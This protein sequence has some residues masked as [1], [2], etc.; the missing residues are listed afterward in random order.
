MPIVNS[1][2]ELPEPEA[3]IWRYMSLEKLLALLQTSR[4]VFSALRT[5]RDP[6]EGRFPTSAARLLDNRIGEALAK[7]GLTNADLT[8]LLREKIF[9]SCWHV[10]EDDSAA[11]WSLYSGTAGVAIRS[12]IGRLKQCLDV[13]P[14]QS[15]L[16]LVKY[17]D[18]DSFETVSLGELRVSH[19]K[20]KSFEHERELRA[21]VNCHD[22][23]DVVPVPVS[24]SMLITDVLVSPE[25]PS[26]FVQVVERVVEKYDYGFPVRQ[27]MLYTL[28]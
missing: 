27:S 25:S 20:R 23:V 6:Y 1:P 11:M 17:V 21:V 22:P 10:N 28:K 19:L 4:L 7:Q 2:L 3:M 16:G 12:T 15:L 8:E 5:L 26:W 18:Y 9:V 13:L 24:C 14:I